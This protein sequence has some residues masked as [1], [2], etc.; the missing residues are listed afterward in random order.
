MFVPQCDVTKCRMHASMFPLQA[1][2]HFLRPIFVRKE[3]NTVMLHIKKMS[4]R[5]IMS[6]RE[7]ILNCALTLFRFLRAMNYFLGCVA[8]IA[9]ILRRLAISMISDTLFHGTPTSETM[10]T[11]AFSLLLASALAL[12]IRPSISLN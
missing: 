7:D 5:N 11:V 3:T 6:V 12:T 1:L 4:N 10:A 8:I 9:L 2:F